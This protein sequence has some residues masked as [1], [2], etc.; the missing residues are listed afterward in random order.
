MNPPSSMGTR[1]FAWKLYSYVVTYDTGFAPNPFF[2]YCTLAC[3]KPAI[4][5]TANIGDWVVGL[6]PKS[7]GSRIV[8]YMRIDEILESFDIYWRDRRFARKKP[9]YDGRLVLKCGDNIYE[10][11]TKGKYRQLKSM[12]SN[13]DK[14]DLERKEHDL[15]GRRILV[16]ETFAYFG[17]EAAGLPP[18]LHQ[19]IVGRAHKCRFSDDV[20]AGF[21]AFVRDVG[22]DGL[23]CS[24]RSWSIEDNS[25]ARAGA[26]CER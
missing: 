6:T 24:P 19:L 26:A 18:E 14:E 16:S 11:R 8:Y 4:R 15:G 5:R 13:G 2:G 1:P 12:H 10:P 20:K 25:W 21:L 22:L 9:R 17:N 7:A 23:R 3:C